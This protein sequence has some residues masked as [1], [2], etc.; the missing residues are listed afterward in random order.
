[1]PS[2]CGICIFTP[3]THAQSWESLDFQVYFT[4]KATNVGFGYWSHDLGG[5]MTPSPPELYTRWIQ[6]GAFSPIFRTHCTKN[7]LNDRRIWV[8]PPVS[9][10]GSMHYLH[11]VVLYVTSPVLYT[12]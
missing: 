4:L 10:S 7:P 2:T 1:M 11:G 6:W 9:T 12:V 8:Y 3:P 5:H